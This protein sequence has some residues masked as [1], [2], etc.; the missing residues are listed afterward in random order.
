[1]IF[2]LVKVESLPA[3]LSKTVLS[4]IRASEPSVSTV[5]AERRLSQWAIEYFAVC[6]CRI[7]ASVFFADSRQPR[8]DET[9][10]SEVMGSALKT[11]VQQVTPSYK[12]LR[13]CQ[14]S[15]LIVCA[16]A[17]AVHQTPHLR[18]AI[19]FTLSANAFS[20]SLNDFLAL[21]LPMAH[22][23]EACTGSSVCHAALARSQR[24]L[25]LDICSLFLRTG[26]LASTDQ[27]GID[28]A[29][30]VSLLEKQ[31][32][33]ATAIPACRVASQSF[34]C[35]GAL[36]LVEQSSPAPETG[37][38]SDWRAR[39]SADLLRNATN[40]SE[41][42]IHTVGEVCRDLEDRCEVV[43]QPLRE[44]QERSKN[45]ETQLEAARTRTAALESQAEERNLF[46]NGL[47]AEKN[48]LE[49]QLEASEAR[50]TQLTDLHHEMDSK[51]AAARAEA[52]RSA[53]AAKDEASDQ[54]LKH[55]AIVSTMEDTINDQSE[56]IEQIEL[57]SKALRDE[58]TAVSHAELANQK[59]VGELEAEVAEGARARQVEK[60]SSV[61]KDV[62]IESLRSLRVRLQAEVEAAQKV[63]RDQAT[64]IESLQKELQSARVSSEED[65]ESLKQT[66]AS[67][68]QAAAT[69]VA[70]M[71][72]DHQEETARLRA[73][74]QKA[75]D[76]ASAESGKRDSTI[77][78]LERKIEK[79]LKERKEKAKEFAEAQDL[80]TKLMAVM[81][82]KPDQASAH[83][84]NPATSSLKDIFVDSPKSQHGSRRQTTTATSQSFESSTSSKSGPTPKRTRPRRS[85]RTLSMQQAKIDLGTKTVKTAHDTTSRSS[86]EPLKDLSVSV[87]NKSPVRTQRHGFGKPQPEPHHHWTD[88]KDQGDEAMEDDDPSFGG[89]DIFTSTE[90]EQALAWDDQGHSQVYEESTA[91]F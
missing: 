84:Y 62:D 38:S 54:D 5:M 75:V 88:G 70:R 66:H 12:A 11:A 37:A 20:R 86:R 53:A 21:P 71:V 25:Q 60:V 19:L 48:S 29:L 33:F 63:I 27:A 15:G 39:L 17:A 43:E 55:I 77:S 64:S 23:A 57:S 68:R 44:E 91:D 76:T 30:A 56:R 46:L 65:F 3:Q 90:K 82:L 51:F 14:T 89:S 52:A 40:H 13:M 10:V 18:S 4:L 47:D 24:K 6:V 58:L 8:M 26:L 49:H 45:F 61:Q 87:H 73:D 59:R 81:G 28:P 78:G 74:L 80:S 22:D 36:P 16:F 83:S 67:D 1:M 42:I 32:E 34:H 50:V 35:N 31:V 41:S 9:F 85:T 2:S 69:E 79:L 7:W 72:H